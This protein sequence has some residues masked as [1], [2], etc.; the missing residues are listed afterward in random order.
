MY[1]VCVL[2]SGSIVLVFATVAPTVIPRGNTGGVESCL[3]PL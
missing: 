2:G 1:C 3:F